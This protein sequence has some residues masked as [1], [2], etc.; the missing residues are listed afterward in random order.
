MRN[1]ILFILAFSVWSCQE[2]ETSINTCLKVKL[3]EEVCGNAIVQVVDEQYFDLADT[4]FDRQDGTFLE[5]VFGTST[6]CIEGEPLTVGTTYNVEIV[7]EPAA[8][9]NCTVCLAI[10]DPMP[11][12]FHYIKLVPSCQLSD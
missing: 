3:V 6:A 4:K 7:S 10:L 12:R 1:I 2:E 9:Q 11:K 5:H 8:P